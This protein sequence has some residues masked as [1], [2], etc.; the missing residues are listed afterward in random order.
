MVS[1]LSWAANAVLFVAACYLAANTANTIFAAMLAPPEPAD[2]VE[3]APAATPATR[4]DH[5]EAILARNLFQSSTVAVVPQES[6]NIE[7]LEETK[8]PLDLLGTTAAENPALAWAAVMDKEL[9]KTLVVSIGDVLKEKAEVLRIERRRLVL[10]ENG[11][12][13]ELTFGDD[14]AEA[15]PVTRAPR[16]TARRTTPPRGRR[17]RITRDDVNQALRDP[18][19]ILSQARFLPKY[20]G[21]EMKGFQVNAIK[22]DSVLKDVGLQ[23]GDVITE[24]NGIPINS[25]QE[26]AKL[27]QELGESTSFSIQVEG[28][29]GS[30]R[31]I[32]V[33]L[34][35]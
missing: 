35:E 20:D 27:L 24:F 2:V 6:E 18:S 13:R 32:D 22:P 4:V 31:D 11:E 14:P 3:A 17:A 30:P 8:L 1:Y 21:G 16:R 34:D 28:K 23:N 26:S 29:D 25:P 5:R 10:R 7:D 33:D 19:D 9:R 12:N 15:S